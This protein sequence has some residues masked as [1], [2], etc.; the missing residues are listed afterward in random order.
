MQPLLG[1]PLV[2]ENRAGAGG[3]VGSATVAKGVPD[4]YTWLVTTASHTNTPPFS[5]N[6]PFDPLVDY[7]AIGAV[8]NLAARLCGEAADGEILVSGRLAAAAEA[9]AEVEDRWWHGIGGEQQPDGGSIEVGGEAHPELAAGLHPLQGRLQVA[10][11]RCQVGLVR[12][13]HALRL[14][15]MRTQ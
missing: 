7:T 4:G 10:P 1:Q 2:V 9:V 5:K 13:R 12:R 6:V 3:V 8:I 11:G 15:M 14:G